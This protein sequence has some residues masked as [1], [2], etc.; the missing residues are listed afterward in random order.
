M[1]VCTVQDLT[2]MRP[3]LLHTITVPPSS[4]GLSYGFTYTSG[5]LTGVSAPGSRPVSITQ[6]SGRISAIADP[7]TT[8]VGF[9]YSGSDTRVVTRTDPLSHVTT[10]TY[11][12][13]G[14]L[15][16]VSVAMASPTP[17]IVTTFDAGEI[18]GMTGSAVADTDLVYT[19]VNGPRTDTTVTKVWLDRFGAPRKIVDAMGDTTKIAHGDARWPALVTQVVDASGFTI[20]ATYDGR[21]NIATGTAVH[22]LAVSG[23]A[24]TTYAYDGT[25]DFA[26]RIVG[27]TGEVWRASIDGATGN[28]TSEALTDTGSVHSTSYR[29]DSTCGM[30]RSTV[31]AST[32]P[33]SVKYDAL[34]NPSAV[35][36]PR[37]FWTVYRS[38]A[39]GRVVAD[40]S[41]TGIKDS[42]VYDVMDR[43][44]KTMTS[45]P[46]RNGALAQTRTV[47]SDYDHV[48]R[49]T[50]VARSSSADAA[51]VGTI[52]TN[53]RY[54]WSGR[55]VAEVATDGQ[56]DSTA[57]DPAGNAIT[58]ITRLGGTSHPV[59]MRYDALNRMKYRSVPSYTYA[60]ESIGLA[61]HVSTE[62]WAHKYPLFTNMPAGGDSGYTVPAQ[63]DTMSYDAVGRVLIANNGDAKV[64]RKYYPGGMLKADTTRVR[65]LAD[66]ASGSGGDF[67]HHVY[68]VNYSYDLAGRVTTLTVP[69]QLAPRIQPDTLSAV[70][71]ISG[72]TQSI[73]DQIAYTYDTGSNG[74]GWLTRVDGL[75]PGDVF[76]YGYAPRGEIATLSS[77]E[78]APDGPTALPVH[79]SRSYDDDG[80]L[81]TEQVLR[82]NT[83][84]TDT[85][86]RAS[87]TV[88]AEGRVLVLRDSARYASSITRDSAVYLY[89]GLGQ[90]LSSD[91]ETRS[92]DGF[93][94]LSATEG[95]SYDALGNWVARSNAASAAF[96]APGGGSFSGTHAT[97][98]ARYISAT[99]RLKGETLDGGRTDTLMYDAAGNLHAMVTVNG[100]SPEQY[101]D[102]V[103]YYSV[104]GKLV[105]ADA[106]SVA[107][108]GTALAGHTAFEEYRYDALGRRIWTRARRWCDDTQGAG[109]GPDAVACQVSSV[110]RTVWD[111][112][113]ELAEIEMPATD[114][115][116]STTIENDT[117]AITR[118]VPGTGDALYDANRLY[119]QVLYVNGLET[120]QPLAITRNHYAGASS[121]TGS[122]TYAV[123]APFSIVPLWNS[124]GRADRAVI[125]VTAAPGQDYLCADTGKTRCA[126]VFLDQGVFPYARSGAAMGAWNGTVLVDKPDATGTYYRRN[127]SY[128]PA[129]ARFTQEDPIGLAGGINAYGFA[130]GD[131]VNFSDPFG[132]SVTCVYEQQTGRMVCTDNK[133]GKMVVN[134]M[135]YAGH[136]R[137][138]NNSSMQNISNTG[139]LP[140]GKYDIEAPA[141]MHP[142]T[143]PLSL[144]LDPDNGNEM[145]GRSGFLIHGDSKKRPG[146]A[147][148]GCII[149]PAEDRRAI[150]DAG[151]GTVTVVS[152]EPRAEP[153]THKP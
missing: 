21:G 41:P 71:M 86:R 142:H 92:P 98:S 122:A 106:R 121:T 123:Y 36:S 18:K 93:T 79:E 90:M 34:C 38:D 78:T 133:T 13:G 69:N 17:A 12:T 112:S 124:Q 66:T 50:A 147:S 151:G 144:R 109:G 40:S 89:S 44:T 37:G 72:A 105:A 80:S 35:K 135:G 70:L 117:L 94:A 139:P 104:D 137:G 63:V 129:T 115:T 127:R 42:V 20:N 108:G 101:Q 111:G 68:G 45:G 134:R 33:D 3:G 102:R 4:A 76:R 49:L 149:L 97:R 59:V 118:T 75:L 54:D 28:R 19:T 53:Y 83:A 29:Y 125:G 99:D 15:S 2:P 77:V 64:S 96:S 150:S 52:I 61:T 9:G 84:V 145:F 14:T 126:N 73:K 32:A 81:I 120:D 131:P 1:R 16:G 100:G 51:G 143:G 138:K 85:L 5:L 46:A 148:N 43:V 107:F 116:A 103:S 48:G 57:Y 55:R 141:F 153:S 62:K 136:G 7:D 128:D 56:V 114:S 110:R 95:A 91:Y 39:I 30:V 132:L 65:T 146:E 152:G 24:V 88:D 130:S 11:G 8:T 31:E 6:S 22:P 58:V 10:F 140:Q 67:T 74:T 47:T 25:Y 60:S 23:D 87:M 26:N 119:G 113:H 82:T 27:P